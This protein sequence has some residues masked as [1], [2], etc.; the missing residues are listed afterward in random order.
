MLRCVLQECVD[1]R[2]LNIVM[3]AE[4]TQA[5]YNI[6]INKQDSMLI[7][8][9]GDGGKLGFSSALQTSIPRADSEPYSSGSVSLGDFSV[10]FTLAKL[11]GTVLLAVVSAG[12]PGV[13]I[14][15]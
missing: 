9:T 3:R 4:Q 1:K 15:R 5:V 10:V 14:T 2:G 6:I 11:P 13:S 7:L 8:P 12:K